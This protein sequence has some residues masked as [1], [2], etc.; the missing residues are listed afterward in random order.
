M[1]SY[2]LFDLIEDEDHPRIFHVHNEGWM[3]N[4]LD[5]EKVERNKY[6]AQKKR[7]RSLEGELLKQQEHHEELHEELGNR[8]DKIQHLEEQVRILAGHL[9]RKRARVQELEDYID[10]IL[11][12]NQALSNQV[13][14]N[15]EDDYVIDTPADITDCDDDELID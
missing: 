4:V 10:E 8:A 15:P 12:E 3:L 9:A 1:P 13:R 7:K 2:Q 5:H 6:E 11:V 14:G